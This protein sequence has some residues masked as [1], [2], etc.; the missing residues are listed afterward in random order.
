ML[1]SPRLLLM[2]ST[3]YFCWMGRGDHPETFL[4]KALCCQITASW[5]KVRGGGGG[6][7]PR[8]LYCHLLG[9]GIGVLSIS[10]FPISIFPFPIPNSHLQFP[11]PVPNPCPQSQAQ[12]QAQSQSLDNYLTF[13]FKVSKQYVEF[14]PQ[15]RNQCGINFYG[16]RIKRYNW[17]YI[18]LQG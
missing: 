12:A 10:L 3:W 6:W 11:S 4:L 13:L 15:S 8:A 7:W 5:L 17:L 1:D 9:L 2:L 14:W 18:W 16:S